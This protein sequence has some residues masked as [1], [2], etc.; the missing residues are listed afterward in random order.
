MV[1]NYALCLIMSNSDNKIPCDCGRCYIVET[2]RPSEVRIKENRVFQKRIIPLYI[3]VIMLIITRKRFN[4]FQNIE[5]LLKFH[6]HSNMF[7]FSAARQRCKRKW[8]L[9][10]K[11]RSVFC[12][13]RN[14]NRSS[15]CNVS[16]ANNFK[17]IHHVRQTFFGS[18]DSSRRNGAFAR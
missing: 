12:D 13:S 5:K 10:N 3:T 2:S 17:V 7:S 1:R 16:F 8:R 15:L 4:I 6:L 18:I 14:Q 9:H 11:T